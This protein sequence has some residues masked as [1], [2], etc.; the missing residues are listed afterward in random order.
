MADPRPA[1][2]EF[3]AVAVVTLAVGMPEE[4]LLIKQY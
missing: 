4:D 3:R 2:V 1:L